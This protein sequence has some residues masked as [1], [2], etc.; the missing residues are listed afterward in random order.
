MTITCSTYIPV[1]RTSLYIF[2]ALDITIS[3]LVTFNIGIDAERGFRHHG[4]G[5]GTTL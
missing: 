2:E 4:G 3:R 5:T 1:Q